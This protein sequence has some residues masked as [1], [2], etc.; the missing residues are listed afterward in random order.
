MGYQ[1]LNI[2]ERENIL[3]MRAEQKSM[4]QI[5][6]CL[7]R[8]AGTISRELRRNVSSTGE[9]KPHLA[10]RY[11]RQRRVESKQP[12]RLEEDAWLCRYVRNR[13]KQ[14]WSPEQISGTLEK[15]YARVI[16]PVTIYS[17]VY[18]NRIEGGGFYRYLRLSHRWRRRRRAGID[19]R[20][21]MPHRRMID[22]RPRIVQE[23]KRIGDWESDTL[24]GQKSKGLLATHV[25]RKSRY[26]V[27]VKVKDKSAD[28]VTRATLA[29]MKKLPKKKVK[30]M[31]FDNGKEFAGFKELERGLCMRSYFANPYHS[32]ERGTNENTNGLLRQFF[33]KGTNFALVRQ[34][35]V[36]RVIKLLN[37][38]PRKCLNYRTPAEVF[39]GKPMCCASG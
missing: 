25:E 24:E 8:D 18:R 23:R 16:S 38:R 4:R 27:A 26:T 9:Y 39:W 13:L 21:Q 37:N 10:Q 22:K 36:D 14:R 3:K 6:D 34:H 35:Q 29:A 17:W 28:T 11:Y 1:H 30:T 15:D 5:A 31:T 7:G 19:H 32:W 33:P 20:G 2:D 12:E